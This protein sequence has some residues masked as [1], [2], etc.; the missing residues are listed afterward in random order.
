MKPPKAAARRNAAQ[1]TV[2]FLR[3]LPQTLRTVTE[4]TAN[5]SS[6]PTNAPNKH[7]TKAIRVIFVYKIDRHQATKYPTTNISGHALVISYPKR[8]FRGNLR[9]CSSPIQSAQTENF[10]IAAD[11]IDLQFRTQQHP[12]CLG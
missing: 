1:P 3:G 4:K 2:V 5:P 8:Q 6:R 9:D 10:N 11:A 7:D 12:G